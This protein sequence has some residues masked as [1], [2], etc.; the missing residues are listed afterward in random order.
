MGNWRGQIC[1]TLYIGVCP[2]SGVHTTIQDSNG[3]LM[4]ILRRAAI[5]VHL[6][7]FY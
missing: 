7:R 3:A 6:N 2:A 1:M 4:L 5:M